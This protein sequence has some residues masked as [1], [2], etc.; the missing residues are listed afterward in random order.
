MPSDQCLVCADELIGKVSQYLEK[1]QVKFTAFYTAETSQ[2]VIFVICV[3]VC[4]SMGRVMGSGGG[5]LIESER[6][7][8][9]VR[10]DH[11]LTAA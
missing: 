10:E 6:E 2:Q 7:R 9:R 3:D 4:V 5:G 1:R 11:S 8:S